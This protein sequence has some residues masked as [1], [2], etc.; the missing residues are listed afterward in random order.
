MDWAAFGATSRKVGIKASNIEA[1]LGNLSA[2]IVFQKY[3]SKK[4]AKII[5]NYLMNRLEFL[6]QI[7]LITQK[8]LIIISKKHF[9]L[10]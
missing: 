4:N 10:I 3:F 9:M 2:Q 6:W 7:M 5:L 1:K 8:Q